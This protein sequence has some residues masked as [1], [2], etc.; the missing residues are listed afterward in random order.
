MWNIRR[1]ESNLSSH[2]DWISGSTTLMRYTFNEI[3]A[4]TKNFSRVNI[5][6]TR[7]FG[8]VP[9]EHL[10]GKK[11][12]IKLKDRQM[13]CVTY[14][15]WS[16]VREGR[17]LDV[18]ENNILY[19]GPLKVMEKYV[20][21]SILY[22]NLP[23]YARPI[24]EEVVNMLETE[25]HVS[26]ILERTISLITDLDYIKRSVSSSGGSELQLSSDG[27]KGFIRN[28][29]FY[30]KTWLSPGD[31]S[32]VL[33]FDEDILMPL[34]KMYNRGKLEIKGKRVVDVYEALIRSYL[35]TGGEVATLSFMKWLGLAIYFANAP[36]SRNFPMNSKKVVNV[37]YLESLLHYKFQDPSLLVE[38]LIHESYML[39][40]I[41][42]CYQVLGDVIES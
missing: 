1:L 39:P 14:L 3:K 8:V 10:S 2:L 23:L 12:I 30:L 33:S 17:A 18:L 28:K 42:R 40:E 6:G 24:I 11:A 29:P 26:T 37:Q 20:L 9:L 22:S 16:L 31:N 7:S 4:T 32:R 36:L 19:F 15:A 34:V 21:V 35:D 41:R 13:N 25:I 27:H 38:T 5:V